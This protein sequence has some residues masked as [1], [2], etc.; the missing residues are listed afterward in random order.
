MERFHYRRIDP[1]SKLVF[2]VADLPDVYRLIRPAGRSNVY[3]YNKEYRHLLQ[4]LW[5]GK[6]AEAVW[7]RYQDLPLGK[8]LDEMSAWEW[9]SLCL[10]YLI[11]Q[12]HFRPTG[13]IAGKTLPVFDMV[14]RSIQGNLILA[15]CKKSTTRHPPTPEFVREWSHIT[16]ASKT[17]TK[18]QPHGFWFAYGG[19]KGELPPGV[20]LVGKNEM[21]A[22]L[23]SDGKDYLELFRNR[24][25]SDV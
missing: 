11:Q 18:Q 25:V 2:D 9:E 19:C 5:E 7:R 14:G 17:T 16:K 6:T 20:R 4:V 10:G 1:K 8:W 12:E 13:L 21:L 3:H 23:E 15:Q 22:W 24:L